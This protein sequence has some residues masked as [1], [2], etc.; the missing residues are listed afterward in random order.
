MLQAA[1][2]TLIDSRNNL[3]ETCKDLSQEQWFA[4]PDGFANNVA[5]NIGH[6]I[7]AQNGLI[8]TRLGVRG[9]IRRPFATLYIPGT[10]HLEWESNPDTAELL[11][12]LTGNPAKLPEDIA[13]G[14]FEIDELPEMPMLPKA[15]S[16]EHAFVHNQWHEGFHMGVIESILACIK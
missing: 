7:V 4:V 5:W 16:V 1:A 2:R 10:S 15:H 13:A 11:A 8:Y 9:Y 6:L 14:K 3:H 12:L